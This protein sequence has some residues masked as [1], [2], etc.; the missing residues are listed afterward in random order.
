MTDPVAQDL[1]TFT[2]GRGP[3]AE[4]ARHEAA[5]RLLDVY[6]LSTASGA[7]RAV[8]IAKSLAE[9]RNDPSGVSIWGEPGRYDLPGAVLA[10]SVAT[11]YRDMNDSYFNRESLH[12]SDMV[13]ALWGLAE[14]TGATVR[15]LLDA[16]CVA[17]DVAVG[18]ADTWRTSARGADHVNL[19]RFGTVAGAVC[20]LGLDAARAEQAFAIAATN[21][22]ATRQTRRGNLTM[23][24]GYAAGDSAVAGLRAV[25][26]AAAGVEGPTLSFV[27]DMGFQAVAVDPST[28]VDRWPSP[29]DARPRILDTHL[30]V[31]PVGYLAQAP[32]E[33]A[34]TLHGE[35]AG[36]RPVAA[37]ISTYRRAKEIMADPEKWNPRSAETADHSLPY[38]VA[39]C[40]LDGRVGTDSMDPARWTAPDVAS[41]LPRVEVV[42][43]EGMT[44]AY[45][46][47]MAARIEVTTDTGEQLA[48]GVP[49]PLG[50]ARRPLT[51]DQLLS[52]SLELMEPVLGGEGAR[53]TAARLLDPDPEAPAA[54]LAA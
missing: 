44:A 23:W 7:D 21:Q 14:Q 9:P 17:Y 27:G 8:R 42:V 48:R 31:Y 5:R 3:A 49:W 34:T 39:V 28:W 18:M 1:A 54:R 25:R 53:A 6:S 30:K 2:L 51:D 50:H 32:A 36:R 4:E 20:L 46:T 37:R 22:I 47:E 38:I 29:G 16:V 35:L 12:P 24:K 19:I 26:M 45:P 41:L 10:N 52:R 13:P 40:L 33:V 15:Q 11:R 43:D